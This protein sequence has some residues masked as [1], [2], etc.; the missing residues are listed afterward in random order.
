MR[1]LDDVASRVEDPYLRHAVALALRARGRT[2]PNPLVGCVV[3]ADGRIVGEGFH[4]RAGQPHAEVVALADAGAS[5]A[6]ADVYV[7]L[8][9]CSHHGRTPPCTEALIAAGVSRVVVGMRDPNTEA[10]GGAGRLAEA[11]IE[12]SFAADPAPFAAL[13]AGWLKRLAT[14]CPMVVV[15]TALSLDGHG[16]FS[17]GRRAA[18]TGASGADVTATLRR[19][20]DAVLV[21]AATVIA[22]D[23]ALTVRT[24]D[25]IAEEHQPLRVVLVG[26][27]VPAIDSKVFSDSAAPTLVLAG[28]RAP[29][30]LLS[31]LLDVV[32]VQRFSAGEGL[33]AAF[34]A[35]G[36]RGIG[37]VLVEPGPR[38]LSALWEQ[39]MIDTL[40][41]VVAGGMAGAG[42]PPPYRGAGDIEGSALRHL[43]AP[44]E[45]GIVGDVAVT[46]WSPS[47]GTQDQ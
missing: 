33:V 1:L 22:D 20:A 8:E 21:G 34:R 36:E 28:D 32:E 24:S 26:Q 14:G 13:N 15:K 6:G 40:V 18:I 44:V 10:A 45:A 43:M 16:A 47:P 41:T 46:V 4:S 42:S 2:A 35:L 39:R 23:P 27:H 31:S 17:A 19:R 9:P 7:T 25:G 30:E 3:V 37:E 5:A 11:G 12:V 29:D 38:L